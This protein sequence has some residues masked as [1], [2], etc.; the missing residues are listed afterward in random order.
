[1]I[2]YNLRYLLKMEVMK[3]AVITLIFTLTCFVIM[4]IRNDF[5]LGL[6]VAGMTTIKGILFFV[7]LYF[8]LFLVAGIWTLLDKI[9]LKMSK[10][11]T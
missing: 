10:K 11:R 1:M 9:T 2:N 7:G 3:W 8:L 5:L 6:K 4:T